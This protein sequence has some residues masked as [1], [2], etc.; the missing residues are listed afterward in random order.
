MRL[1]SDEKCMALTEMVLSA[2]L[3]SVA[4]SAHTSALLPARAAY[5]Q[6]GAAS[7]SSAT[8]PVHDTAAWLKQ[9]VKPKNDGVHN[10]PPHHL[11]ALSAT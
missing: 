1:G 2:T 7:A 6:G 11:A 3:C 5:P 9:K 8:D 10:Q 4:S